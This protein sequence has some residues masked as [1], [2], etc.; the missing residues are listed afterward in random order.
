VG[1]KAAAFVKRRG[2]KIEWKKKKGS[3][4]TTKLHQEKRAGPMEREKKYSQQ[5][6]VP[7]STG[8]CRK[9]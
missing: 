4:L 7:Q 1:A 9:S 6:S 5:D 8:K 2:E 3:L